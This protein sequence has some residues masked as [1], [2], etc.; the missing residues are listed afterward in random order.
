MY[1]FFCYEGFILKFPVRF[2][3]YYFPGSGQLDFTFELFNGNTKI[4]SGST[5]KIELETALTGKLKVSE[6]GFPTG[7][8]AVFF[9]SVT[10]DKESLNNSSPITMI[11]NG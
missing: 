8:F 6:S 4:E 9:V 2:L 11:T 3:V 10:V 7:N 5:T 1:V